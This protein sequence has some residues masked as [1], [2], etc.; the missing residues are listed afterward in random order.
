MN[1]FRFI[2]LFLILFAGL[3]VIAQNESSQSLLVA[4]KGYISD[5]KNIRLMSDNTI[6]SSYSE[7][8]KMHHELKETN[9]IESPAGYHISYEHLYH[10]KP[11]FNSS[12]KVHYSKTGKLIHTQNQ[13]KEVRGSTRSMTSVLPSEAIFVYHN[14]EYQLGT[15]STGGSALHPTRLIAVAGETIHE[16]YRKLYFH[17]PDSLVHAKVF[18]VNPV[19]SAGVDYGGAYID[20]KDSN[21]AEL[22]AELKSVEMRVNFRNDTFF[23]GDARFIFRN[24][25]DPLTPQVFSLTDSFNFTRDEVEFEDVNAFYH[26]S[27]YA[28][29]VTDMGFPTLLYDTLVVDANAGEADFSAFDPAPTPKTLEFGLGGVDD[30]EDGEVVIHEMIH[31]LS[32]KA[33]PLTVRGNDRQA[34]EEG[35]CDYLASTYSKKYSTYKDWKVFSWDAHNEFWAGFVN[36]SMKN[37]KTQ[38]TGFRDQD[39]EIWSS[40]L[41]CIEGKLGS[42]ITDSLVFEH[43]FYQQQ[44]MTMPGMAK[45]LMKMDTLQNNGLHGWAIRT[46]FVDHGILEPLG[47]EDVNHSNDVKIKNSMAFAQGIGN[48]EIEFSK[49]SLHTIQIHNFAGQLIQTFKSAEGLFRLSPE[50]LNSGIYI[51]SV[52][53]NEGFY[54]TKI[55]RF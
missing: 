21:S 26:L 50:Q 44:N 3:N 8:F 32:T 33:S 20:N 11:V 39:R 29:Y 14:G 43:L 1:S 34:M 17:G 36:N 16:E 15:V 54:Q 13:L 35:N 47:Y 5:F 18:L 4:E 2:A 12:L 48:L 40:A 30:A 41:M 6:R 49:A 53:G 10:N 37:Y 22:E 38:R 52:S 55:R 7:Y 19:N 27:N 31:A 46:C 25:N 51:L 45:V 28:K 42:N 9:A 23:L 24:V